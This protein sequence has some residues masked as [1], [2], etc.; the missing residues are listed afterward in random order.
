[1]FGPPGTLYVYRSYGVHLCANLV[2]EPAH[3][4]AAVLLRALEPLA[5]S[6]RMRSNRGL[7]QD[8][9]AKLIAGGP[10]RLT[11]AM[12]IQHEHDGQT[13]QRGKITLREPLPGSAP[14]KI[15]TATRIG[16]SK[17]VDRPYRFCAESSDCLSKPVPRAKPPKAW[18]TST[19]AY[20]SIS[21]TTRSPRSGANSTA[22]S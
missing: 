18:P 8:R 15:A 7:T 12:E 16:I 19:T 20:S 10:G 21:C 3:T 14:L 13:L 22:A 4:A 11:Q 5:G 6:I 2:C 1:M 17:A 9:A